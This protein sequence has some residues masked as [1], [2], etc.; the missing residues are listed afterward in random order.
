MPTKLLTRSLFAAGLAFLFA[1]GPILLAIDA[2]ADTGKLRIVTTTSDLAAITREITGDLADVESIARSSQ[3]AHAIQA[4]PSFMRKLNRADLLIYT[5]LDL[6]VGWLPLLIQ[7]ARNPK[8]TAGGLGHLDASTS[9]DRILEKH[10]GPVDRSMGDVHP[11]GN[12]HYLLNPRNGLRVAEAIKARLIDVRPADS[13]VFEK[14]YQAFRD[15]LETRIAG[16]ERAANPF[17][18]QSIVTY[19]KQWEYLADWLGLQIAGNVEAKPGI[20]PSPGHVAALTDRMQT[21]NIRLIVSAAYNNTKGAQR[22]ADRV[23]AA[24]LILP[25]SPAGQGSTARYAGFFEHIVTRLAEA[26]QVEAP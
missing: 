18:G 4:K 11:E 6:E 20:S 7:G 23:G 5:G 2:Y 21:G 14:N 26:L 15:D 12:P 25:V 10:E 8:V 17:R 19:H 9:I 16:W 24:H 3:D 1:L 22:I 13:E